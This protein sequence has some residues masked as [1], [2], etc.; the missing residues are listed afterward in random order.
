M[1]ASSV[2]QITSDLQL[3]FVTNPLILVVLSLLSLFLV[4]LSTLEVEKAQEDLHWVKG[5]WIKGLACG[6]ASAGLI[7]LPVFLVRRVVSQYLTGSPL[8]AP[9]GTSL[10]FSILT[11]SLTGNLLEE[12]LYRGYL[13]S[14]FESLKLSGLRVILLSA[15]SFSAFHSYLGF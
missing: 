15:I 9:E 11:L 2:W 4:F 5:S 10:I 12:V 13:Q 1:I 6:L 14:Y 3:R 7:Y 8:P